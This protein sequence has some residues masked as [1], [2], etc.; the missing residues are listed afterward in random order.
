VILTAILEHHM[1]NL[2][3]MNFEDVTFSMENLELLHTIIH[4]QVLLKI[5]CV[6][7]RSRDWDE[8]SKV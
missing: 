7:L 2:Q 1:D 6:H 8:D 5:W 4:N 3:D